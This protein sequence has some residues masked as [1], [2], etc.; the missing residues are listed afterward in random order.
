ML[1][2]PDGK[3]AAVSLTFDDAR[4]SQIDRGLGILDAFGVKATF[5]VSP[6]NVES[7]LDGWRE[8]AGAGHEIGNH[9]LNHP[10]SGNFAFARDTALEDYTLERM[11][12]ELTGANDAI[13]RLLGVAPRTF[14]YPCGQKFVG[15]GENVQ[16]YV[17]LV[18]RHFLVGRGAFGES[19]N[20]PV[21]C[22][23]AQVASM[24]A[25]GKTFPQLRALLDRAADEGR[26]L[27]LFGHEIGQ[28]DRDRH[29]TVAAAALDR[30]CEY[31]K[32]PDSRLWVET[33]AA[34]GEHIRRAR[35][36]GGEESP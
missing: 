30:L 25:D 15:R 10:C 21:F 34:V 32:R 28:A 14:A 12:A 11:E 36:D 31:L 18:A 3:C 29:Q 16:S 8:A 9:T 2:W 1:T 35:V 5:Y 17:P 7:R 23:L 6:G 19:A 20:D 33:V 22:D 27:V 13:G 4:V 26:W 24:A